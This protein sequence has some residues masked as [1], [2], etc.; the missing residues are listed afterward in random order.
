MCD[1]LPLS[2]HSNFQRPVDTTLQLVFF[3]GEEA[4]EQWSATDSLYGSRHLAEKWN[5]TPFTSTESC[6][7]DYISELDRIEVLVLLDLLGTKNP[8]FYSF[9]PNTDALY[10]RLIRIGSC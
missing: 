10:G 1:C 8:S 4:F 9:F 2:R 5:K 7:A 6:P 3:D